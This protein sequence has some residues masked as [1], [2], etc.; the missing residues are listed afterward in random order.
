MSAARVHPPKN[1]C[2]SPTALKPYDAF[3]SFEWAQG[4][5][6]A[7]V[8]HAALRTRAPHL[9][10]W[11]AL[12]QDAANPPAMASGVR[13][14]AVFVLVATAGALLKPNV[15]HEV[16]CAVQR[17][18]PVVVLVE[19]GGPPLRALLRE[20]EAYEQTDA[21][22]D[23]AAGR[24]HL[25]VQA[26]RDFAQAAESCKQV[27]FYR[28]ARLVGETLPALLVALQEASGGGKGMAAAMQPRRGAGDVVIVSGVTGTLQ[29]LCLAEALRR[30]RP[31][32]GMQV[33]PGNAS[34]EETLEA[35][36]NNLAV[37]LVLSVGA[38]EEAGF[39]AA[40]ERAVKEGK[41]LALVHEADE[42]FG[43]LPFGAIMAA[44]PAALRAQLYGSSTASVFRRK[45]V[46][47]EAMV[48]EVLSKVEDEGPLRGC[49]HRI[50]NS[51]QV[52]RRA[53]APSGPR[54]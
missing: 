53:N 9:R 20:G 50:A 38:W 24:L 37:V 52:K 30:E 13:K 43:G 21:A 39:A 11:F 44:T 8:L 23:A 3:L 18:R 51:Y 7:Q 19:A 14:S 6:I 26:L 15:R 49:D 29:A 54:D 4:L 46:E 42:C 2:S 28:D 27:P 10:V 25:G 48:N 35:L 22:G 34:V 41:R 33:L 1:K 40:A 31:F 12:E 47:A 17:R 36:G 45:A 5:P 16:A 32:H